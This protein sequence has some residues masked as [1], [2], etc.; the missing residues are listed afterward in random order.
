MAVPSFGYRFYCVDFTSHALAGTTQFLPAIMA[1][2]DSHLLGDGITTPSE[3][4]YSF[5]LGIIVDSIQG[6]A[7][8]VHALSFSIIC[9]LVSYKHQLLRN[10]ALWQQA[11]VIMLLTIIQD[12]A[13]FG[14]NFYHHK[15]YSTRKYF[16]IA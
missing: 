13:V 16:G 6:S 9:Y 2:V 8:G 15:Y 4:W 5:I 14:L 11:L 10:M 1:S 3:C 12:L 7:L